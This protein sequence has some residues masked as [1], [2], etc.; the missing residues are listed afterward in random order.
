MQISVYIY[1]FLYIY[2][3]INIHI[4]TQACRDKCVFV[5]HDMMKYRCKYV[6]APHFV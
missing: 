1:V 2:V 6:R 4:Y 5:C 3:Y